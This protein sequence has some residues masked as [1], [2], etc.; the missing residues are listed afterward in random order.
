MVILQLSPTHF[1]SN[2]RHQHRL[3]PGR[4]LDSQA[5]NILSIGSPRL[6]QSGDGEVNHQLTRDLSDQ[7]HLIL[8]TCDSGMFVLQ[9]FES[10]NNIQITSFKITNSIFVQKKMLMAQLV[11]SVQASNLPMVLML[12]IFSKESWVTVGFF[13]LYRRQQEYQE[14]ILITSKNIRSTKLFKNISIVAKMLETLVY[15]DSR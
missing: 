15:F 10:Q 6:F 8:T 2:I 3:K 11:F 5:V 14:M 4:S 1:A 9:C 12:V 7:L 13:Q